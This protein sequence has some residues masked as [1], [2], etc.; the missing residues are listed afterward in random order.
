MHNER[1]ES[2]QWS[3]ACCHMIIRLCDHASDGN[4]LMS[5]II[6]SNILFAVRL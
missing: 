5:Y 4:M 6:I 1:R 3:D 2:A